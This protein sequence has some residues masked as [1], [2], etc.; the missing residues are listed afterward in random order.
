MERTTT[1]HD[2]R[3]EM[4]RLYSTGMSA[5]EVASLLDLKQS[6]VDKTITR[7]LEIAWAA[8]DGRKFPGKQNLKN[9]GMLNKA[10]EFAYKH[11]GVIR[12]NYGKRGKAKRQVKAKQAPAN[13]GQIVWKEM[14]RRNFWQRI[15][16]WFRYAA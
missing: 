4:V 13:T 1:T 11:E 5:E 6:T 14:P 2:Q 9:M 7:V 15:G 3:M 10:A 12:N 8:E 16:D